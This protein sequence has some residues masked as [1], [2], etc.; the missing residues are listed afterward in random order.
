MRQLNSND[1]LFA[2]LTVITVIFM[3]ALFRVQVDVA[4]NEMAVPGEPQTS[5][6]QTETTQQTTTSY[7]VT[8]KQ[9]VSETAPVQT[10]ETTINTSTS[11]TEAPAFTGAW[12][13]NLFKAYGK[14]LTLTLNA[15]TH[16]Q[17]T[18][19]TNTRYEYTVYHREKE[20]GLFILD[21]YELN[22]GDIYY[23]MRM[24]SFRTIP[25]ALNVEL[26]LE[27]D[28][29][30]EYRYFSYPKG[31]DNMTSVLEGPFHSEETP[32]ESPYKI[33]IESPVFSM[34]ASSVNAYEKLEHGILR[35]LT[36]KSSVIQ[37]HKD[38]ITAELPI[39]KGRLTEQWG[40]FSK[41]QLVDFSNENTYSVAKIADYSRFRKWSMDGQ[42]Y[43][44]PSS[45]T[46][47]GND[48]FYKNTAHH[49]G[50]VFLRTQ[51]RYFDAM[52][53]VALYTAISDQTQDGIWPTEP[54]SNW[55]REDYGIYE[56]FYDTRF[57]TDAG[58]FL[59]RGWRKWKDP[60]FL[61]SARAYGDYLVDFAMTHHFE[62]ENGGFLVW[63]YT[64]KDFALLPTHVSLNHLVTEMNFLYELY[65]DTDEPVYMLIADKIKLAVRDT[66]QDWPK[67][68]KDLW[69]A[70]MKDGSY[71]RDDYVNLTLK[72]L[73]YSQQLFLKLHGETDPRFAYL[74]QSKESYLKA[75]NLPLY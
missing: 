58:L 12:V 31:R 70:Y 25:S 9:P 60:A 22:S 20:A 54:E 62:T 3:I 71:G 52:S 39:K 7:I 74:I 10:T 29:T 4:Y 38:Y 47:S 11:E 57:N 35:D 69:Y 64:D 43:I 59:I 66:Y 53:I 42:Y 41:E 27:T 46:P 68:N 28:S 61:A 24:D 32:Y 8:T 17:Y 50:E 34:V 5:Q 30:Y 26:Y 13:K 67:P 33:Y 72:D 15:E 55:L 48:C 40:V 14:D 36:D 65:I 6:T 75:H 37:I 1:K 51:G 21:L 23:C 19:A 49:V 2:F 56:S 16:N 73:K 63:D 45:Y 18:I 44:T